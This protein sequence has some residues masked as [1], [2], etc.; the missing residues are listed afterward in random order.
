V[1]GTHRERL[2]GAGMKRY[3]PLEIG[4]L[5]RPVMIVGQAVGRQT[6]GRES[7]YMWQGSKTADFMM[8]I[9]DGRQNIVLTNALDRY[10]PSSKTIS[11]KELHHARSRLVK[12]IIRY[13]PSM[14]AV[15]GNDAYWSI[16]YLSEMLEIAVYRFYHPSFI[17]RFNLNRKIYMKTLRLVIDSRGMR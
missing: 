14:I 2:A 3:K 8:R 17:M 15:L 5:H 16:Y 10:N 4:P 13:H 12:E 1:Q 9:L 6:K 7:D 11:K